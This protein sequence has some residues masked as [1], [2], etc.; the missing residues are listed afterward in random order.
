MKVPAAFESPSATESP[1]QRKLSSASRK[2]ACTAFS[3]LKVPRRERSIGEDA[4]RFGEILSVSFS[5]RDF[6]SLAVPPDASLVVA[7]YMERIAAAVLSGHAKR[8]K[9]PAL[10]DR[11]SA[12][13]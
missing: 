8:N 11:I 5:G 13:A 6:G 12:A 4:R 9:I 2:P 1:K 3:E 7:E 10:V